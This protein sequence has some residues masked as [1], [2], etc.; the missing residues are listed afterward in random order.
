MLGEASTALRA[1]T[2][3]INNPDWL[4]SPVLGL[5]TKTY[6]YAMLKLNPRMARALV[7][8]RVDTS[9]RLAAKEMDVKKVKDAWQWKPETAKDMQ[10]IE[11][12]LGGF[13]ERVVASSLNIPPSAVQENV[14]AIWRVLRDLQAGNGP[15]RS[16]STRS[17]SGETMQGLL[18]KGRVPKSHRE[19]FESNLAALRDE[20]SGGGPAARY[21]EVAE[22]PALGRE[23]LVPR[24]DMPIDGYLPPAIRTPENV[25]ALEGAIGNAEV[26]GEGLRSR[27]PWAPIALQLSLLGIFGSAVI[28]ESEVNVYA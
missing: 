27:L 24:T 3:L 21:W 17:A 22:P 16:S 20:V 14:W 12:A 10:G 28:R 25:A 26:I 5:A 1:Y 8:D 23:T 11:L 4:S 7:I 6:V 19:L 15:S 13:A 18:S 9:A 2:Q